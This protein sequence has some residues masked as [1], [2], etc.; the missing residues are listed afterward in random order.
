MIR[1]K[2][3]RIGQRVKL[4]DMETTGGGNAYPL[5]PGWTDE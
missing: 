2:G 3:F 1:A 4:H 5:P